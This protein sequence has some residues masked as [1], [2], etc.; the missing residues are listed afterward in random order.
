MVLLVKAR[1]THNLEIRVLRVGTLYVILI[2]FRVMSYFRLVMR[3]IPA[4]V[5][6]MGRVMTII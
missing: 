2:S 1:V 5:V 6:I 3:V 4:I